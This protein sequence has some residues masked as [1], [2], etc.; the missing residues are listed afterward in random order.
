MGEL[1]RLPLTCAQPPLHETG[2]FGDVLLHGGVCL[3]CGLA[4][5]L[6]PSL[7]RS[8]RTLRMA[9]RHQHRRRDA[10]EPA[11]PIPGQAVPAGAPAARINTGRLWRD[12]RRTGHVAGGYRRIAGRRPPRLCLHGNERHRCSQRNGVGPGRSPRLAGSASGLLGAL[13]YGSGIVPS[14]LLAWGS[15]GSPTAML[16]IMCA[17]AVLSAAAAWVRPAAASVHRKAPSIKHSKP[18]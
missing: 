12:G 3:H 7:R 6:H 2:A 10:A 18:I 8:R 4:C 16:W 9:V 11:Q 15:D 5:C 14:A 1:L 13:Q 17:A